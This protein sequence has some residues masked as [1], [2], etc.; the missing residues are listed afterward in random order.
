LVVNFIYI[1]DPTRI[2]P[3]R[4]TT[5]TLLQLRSAEALGFYEAGCQGIGRDSPSL[6]AATAP[7]RA[8]PAGC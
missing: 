7:A 4:P 8:A 5:K 1:R 6:L 3:D 2:W